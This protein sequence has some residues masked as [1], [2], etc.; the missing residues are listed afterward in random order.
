MGGLVVNCTM[1]KTFEVEREADAVHQRSRTLLV[2]C[3][4]GVR[5]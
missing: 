1:M 3:E 2:D 4:W 5:V